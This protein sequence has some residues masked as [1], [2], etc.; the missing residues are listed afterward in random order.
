MSAGRKP[1]RPPGG[2]GTVLDPD[3]TLEVALR[4]FAREGYEASSV[5]AIARDL[6]VSHGLLRHRYGSKQGLWEACIDWSF[7]TMNRDL[8]HQLQQAVESTHVE[9]VTRAIVVEYVTLAARFSDNLL[10]IAQEG[11]LGGP[12]LDYIYERHF[13]RF[14]DLART[15]M[16][17]YQGEGPFREVPWETLFF[18]AFSGGAARYSLRPLARRVEGA[19]DGVEPD[20]ERLDPDDVRAQA[21]AV[22]DIL[23]R[24][25][26]K[27]A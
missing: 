17:T 15:L 21:E 27:P 23:L 5:R 12:R 4:A 13:R 24:G 10:I 26:L 2:A 20:D 11:A 16:S 22:A 19:A 8:T 3:E 7:G 1:G 14:I 6:G 25:I 18:L 9:D